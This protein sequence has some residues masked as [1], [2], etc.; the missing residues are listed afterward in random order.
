MS[1]RLID[2]PLAG[3][4]WPLNGC[5]L[6]FWGRV[7]SLASRGGVCC[8]LRVSSVLTHDGSVSRRQLGFRGTSAWETQRRR[9]PIPGDNIFAPVLLGAGGDGRLGPSWA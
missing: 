4:W 2:L 9:I 3:L 8:P 5:Q 7:I 6:A 1:Q